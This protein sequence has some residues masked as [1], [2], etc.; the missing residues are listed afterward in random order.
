[1]FEC[2][3]FCENHHRLKVPNRRAIAMQLMQRQSPKSKQILSLEECKAEIKKLDYKIT[4][5]E[6]DISKKESELK[7]SQ[8][9][10][11]KIEIIKRIKICD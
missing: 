9:N 10:K 7:D 6:T 5:L 3:F 1:M 2:L 4:K 11:E 8:T